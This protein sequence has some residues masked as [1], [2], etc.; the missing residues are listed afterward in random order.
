MSYFNDTAKLINRIRK[1]IEQQSYVLSEEGLNDYT[2]F[3]SRIKECFLP[4]ALCLTKNPSH[5]ADDHRLMPNPL[6][7][8][9][10]AKHLKKL[11]NPSSFDYLIFDK[12]GFYIS[13]KDAPMAATNIRAVVGAFIFYSIAEGDFLS[14]VANLNKEQ[15]KSELIAK[16]PNPFLKAVLGKLSVEQ[17]NTFI[18][19][20]FGL[21]ALVTAQ[22]LEPKKVKKV[23]SGSKYYVGFTNLTK[24][25]YTS[26]TEEQYEQH[27]S[28]FK[29][30]LGYGGYDIDDWILCRFYTGTLN[31]G[32]KE[33]RYALSPTLGV[34]RPFNIGEYY[35]TK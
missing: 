4:V 23:G 13:Y 15:F 25:S 6:F 1:L 31:G 2:G 3:G 24:S 16:V 5:S 10:K 35:N 17:A 28:T 18:L 8:G 7:D 20:A 26:V 9:L 19:I 32:F 29:S 34:K 11:I 22:P 12:T 21:M 33:S 14:N 30:V 27:C